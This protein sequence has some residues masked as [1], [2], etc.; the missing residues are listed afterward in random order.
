MGWMV[1]P[2]KYV[3]VLTPYPVTVTLF[4]GGEEVFAVINKFADVKMRSSW[5]I[6]VAPKSKEYTYY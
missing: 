6:C 1:A 4:G 5:I 2:Q 3:H